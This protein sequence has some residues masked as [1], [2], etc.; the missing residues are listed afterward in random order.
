VSDRRSFAHTGWDR[1][2]R[3]CGSAANAVPR[4]L[5]CPR[6]AFVNHALLSCHLIGDHGDI[7][8]RESMIKARRSHLFAQM[9]DYPK[10]K[11]V[12]FDPWRF[13]WQFFLDAGCQKGPGVIHC[14]LTSTALP[15]YAQGQSPCS[16][17]AFQAH[18]LIVSDSA[19][20]VPP[21]G[22]LFR[23]PCGRS[24]AEIVEPAGKVQRRTGPETRSTV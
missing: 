8:G 16:T 17:V 4:G 19:V 1:I 3:Y 22:T 18:R 15:T 21:N 2:S 7:L 9:A 11:P 10:L 20:R 12:A 5:F 24:L 13:R 6:F 23:N 14:K